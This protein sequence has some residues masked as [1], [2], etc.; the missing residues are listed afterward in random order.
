MIF[1]P[2]ETSFASNE[3]MFDIRES[4]AASRVGLAMLNVAEERHH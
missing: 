4:S 2:G 3:T 1:Q